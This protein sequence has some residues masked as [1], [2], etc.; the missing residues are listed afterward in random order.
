MWL[1]DCMLVGFIRLIGKCN[2]SIRRP[3]CVW[4]VVRGAVKECDVEALDFGM[5]SFEYLVL[6]GISCNGSRMHRSNHAH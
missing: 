3:D 2:I 5:G 1:I 4:L 6:F